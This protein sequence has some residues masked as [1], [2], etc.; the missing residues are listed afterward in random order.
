VHVEAER[1]AVSAGVDGL[2]ARDPG[3]QHAGAGLD[4]YGVAEPRRDAWSWASLAPVTV[5]SYDTTTWLVIGSVAQAVPGMDAAR[6]SS[7]V[8][9]ASCAPERVTIRGIAP[10]ALTDSAAAWSVTVTTIRP[11]ASRYEPA[12]WAPSLATSVS[13]DAALARVMGA[14]RRRAG[15]RRRPAADR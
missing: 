8:A 9:A 13:A 2:A 6:S 3:G 14:V 11:P 15:D 5:V 7:A 4:A 1:A 10:A 12:D